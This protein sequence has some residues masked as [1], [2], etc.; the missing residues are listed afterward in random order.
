MGSVAA[1]AP[2]VTGIAPGRIAG[3]IR[4]TEDR[5]GAGIAVPLA[6]RPVA[7]RGGRWRGETDENRNAEKQRK[8]NQALYRP[9]T[10]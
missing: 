1:A 7:S 10:V 9:P 8:D 5:A 2:A 3:A 4:R 6:R